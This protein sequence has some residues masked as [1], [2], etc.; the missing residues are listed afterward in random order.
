MFITLA[1]ER[2]LGCQVPLRA[3]YIPVFFAEITRILNHVSA[4]TCHDWKIPNLTGS[5]C[6][7]IIV[8]KVA[9]N[10]CARSALIAPQLALY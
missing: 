4:L 3:Q 8:V 1:V 7:W 6:T 9:R 10:C 2:L 5:T